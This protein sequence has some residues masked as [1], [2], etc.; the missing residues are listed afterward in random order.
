[1]KKFGKL[2]KMKKLTDNVKPR[3]IKSLKK[4]LISL[5]ST[6]TVIDKEKFIRNDL[7][8]FTERRT[9]I[10]D[11]Y[12]HKDS[13]DEERS[14]STLPFAKFMCNEQ[15]WLCIC[16]H[17]TVKKYDCKTKNSQI[18]GYDVPFFALTKTWKGNLLAIS[19]IENKKYVATIDACEISFAKPDFHIINL[20]AM[21]PYTD[22]IP[23]KKWV[24]RCREF[25]DRKIMRCPYV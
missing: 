3:K 14:S 11:L 8:R 12:D 17:L 19:T 2:K 5:L 13:A 21:C 6:T 18:Y 23:E 1:M 4:M 15:K 9:R 20:F 22:L 7:Y 24:P 10:R 16:G 25:M